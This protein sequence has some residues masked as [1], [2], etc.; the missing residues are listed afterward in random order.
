M[1]NTHPRVDG[2]QADNPR[3]D[4]GRSNEQQSRS[5]GVDHHAHLFRCVSN[6]VD[7]IRVRDDATLWYAGGTRGVQN[8][9]DVGTLCNCSSTFDFFIGHVCTGRTQFL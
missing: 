6:G 4:V 9:R 7:K 8:G 2:E 1:S 3:K 5:F